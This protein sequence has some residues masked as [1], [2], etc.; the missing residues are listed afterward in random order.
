MESVDAQHTVSLTKRL[1]TPLIVSSLP[2]VP[3]SSPISRP[4][5][6]RVRQGVTSYIPPSRPSTSNGRVNASTKRAD[7]PSSTVWWNNAGRQ[8]AIDKIS[9]EAAAALEAK[10]A[11]NGA[12]E[13]PSKT[14]NVP[15]G[16][17]G[18]PLLPESS[19]PTS[20]NVIRFIPSLTAFA[21]KEREYDIENLAVALSNAT[22]KDTENEEARTNE[23]EKQRLKARKALLSASAAPAASAAQTARF[24][25]A[26]SGF[27][28]L[29]DNPLARERLLAAQKQVLLDAAKKAAAKGG[30]KK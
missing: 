21:E 9:A 3:G 25:S 24:V 5:T 13:T 4:T 14:I 19:V 6:A 8:E 26:S 2:V 22:L 1:G 30:K 28:S 23:L 10:A 7:R 16:P 15:I 12:D 27:Y 18:F 20:L 11:A 17:A 29:G